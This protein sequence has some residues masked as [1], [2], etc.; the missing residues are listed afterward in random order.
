MTNT[1][2]NFHLAA[3]QADEK[4][5]LLFMDKGA[6]A[7]ELDNKKKTPLSLSVSTP[8]FQLIINHKNFEPTENIGYA[9]AATVTKNDLISFDKLIAVAKKAQL[10]KNERFLQLVA[11][12]V[13]DTLIN[14]LMLDYPSY[15]K[16]INDLLSYFKQSSLL[17]PLLT[18]DNV[19]K[20]ENLFRTLLRNTEFTPKAIKEIIPYLCELYYYNFAHA[21]MSKA[22]RYDWYHDL[23]SDSALFNESTNNYALLLAAKRSNPIMFRIFLYDS[24]NPE[25]KDE[26]G[27][28]AVSIGAKNEKIS[29]ILS[30]YPFYNP[31]QKECN[32]ENNEE[33]KFKFTF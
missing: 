2:S 6:D 12:P 33:N 22:K 11:Q 10:F 32:T 27:E 1:A 5:V 31:E 3:Q 15:W 17:E 28:S 13:L 30:N 4:A 7:N 29:E 25:A 21:I 20:N 18:L 19:L 26:N 14:H 16:R 8:I 23:K 24:A 9:I